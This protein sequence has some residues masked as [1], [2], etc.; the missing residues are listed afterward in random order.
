MTNTPTCRLYLLSPPGFSPAPFADD[1]DKALAAGDAACLLLQ[2]PQ[3]EDGALRDTIAAL[4]PVCHKHD[5]ALIVEGHAEIAADSD[6][7]GVQV[8]AADYAKARG[9]VGVDAIVGVTS[10]R[11]RHTATDAAES[12]ADF[13]AFGADSVASGA[14]SEAFANDD[15]DQTL[16]AEGEIFSQID[17]IRWWQDLIEVPCIALG[18]SAGGQNGL[19]LTDCTALAAAGADFVAVGDAV[20]A[21]KGGPAAGIAAAN[22]AIDTAASAANDT[23][24]DAAINIALDQAT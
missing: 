16:D 2:M 4:A 22:A 10:L 3:A 5:V 1:L 17:M 14:D 20:W 21:H 11:S 13:V 12:A 7:D 19:S 8:A 9:L 18:S 24:A 15:A 23:A 6:A